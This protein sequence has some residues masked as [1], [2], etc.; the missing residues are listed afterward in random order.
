MD[1]QGCRFRIYILT[2]RESCSRIPLSMSQGLESG[3]NKGSGTPGSTPGMTCSTETFPISL[4][5]EETFLSDPLKNPA[6]TCPNRTQISS[7]TGCIQI[8][9]GGSFRSSGNQPPIWTLKPPA[10][11]PGTIK[12]TTIA[13][14]DGSS[15]FTYVQGQ[16]LPE[17]KEDIQRYKVLVTY[18]GKCFDI[19]F[20]ERYFGIKLNQVHI[21]LRYV[22]RSL[23]YAG[24]LKGCERKAGIDRGDLEGA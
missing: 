11:I 12:I 17:F 5:E 7:Q 6:S 20:L 19:P 8:I 21:D 2:E 18:N 13:V 10:W 22:L 3:P 14:Y 1:S 16:N 9:T 24:G 4:Q 23:G 15:I